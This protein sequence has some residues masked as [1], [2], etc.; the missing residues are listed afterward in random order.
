MI[1]L[2]TSE[3]QTSP[4][5]LRIPWVLGGMTLTLSVHCRPR[6]TRFSVASLRGSTASASGTPAAQWW[7]P[8]PLSPSWALASLSQLTRA[9]TRK[10]PFSNFQ[11]LWLFHVAEVSTSNPSHLSKHFPNKGHS[12]PRRNSRVFYRGE[13]FSPTSSPTHDFKFPGR[14]GTAEKESVSPSLKHSVFAQMSVSPRLLSVLLRASDP[15]LDSW[16]MPPPPVSCGWPV[17]PQ[18][19]RPGPRGAPLAPELPPQSMPCRCPVDT[20]IGPHAVHSGLL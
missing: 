12:P 11:V 13:I 15:Y 16:P 3:I 17:L 20:K 18:V 14:N 2:F 5:S 4:R 8:R 6:N 9:F 7:E 10:H 19:L 1:I